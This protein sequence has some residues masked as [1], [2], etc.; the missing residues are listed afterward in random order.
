MNRFLKKSCL[1]FLALWMFLLAPCFTHEVQAATADLRT[2]YAMLWSGGNWSRETSD[3]AMLVNAASYP[4]AV[5]MWLVGDQKG[6]TGTIRYQINQ[7][8]R[9]LDWSENHVQ[10]GSGAPD[11]VIEGIKVSLNGELEGAFDIY[12]RTWE[13]GNWSSWKKNGEV[14]GNVGTGSH[15]KGI[16]AVLR[17]KGAGEPQASKLDPSRP[18]VALTFDDGPRSGNTDRVLAALEAVGGRATFFMVGTNVASNASVIQRMA[19]DGCELGNHSW[20][21]N[22]LH[23]MGAAD[24]VANLNR[25]ADA[26]EAAC[27]ARPTLVRTPGGGFNSTVSSA[28][29]SMGMP[30]IYWSIDTRDWEHKNTQ[31]TV[32]AV[33]DHVRDGDIVLMHDIHSPT[34]A[35]A[36]IIIPELAARGYQLVTVSELAAMRGGMNPGTLY[37]HF[38]P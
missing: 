14:A 7:G 35:A 22:S 31:K 38:R 10:T 1:F 6:R 28:L 12:Y 23:K 16:Q 29:A 9:W 13:Q 26:V 32:S 33:L 2:G 11:A 8:G 37:Y 5:Q 17:E 34:I 19:A 3:G 18:M 4:T 20:N 36:E 27:G 21:H 15:I 30:C 24:I 25:T